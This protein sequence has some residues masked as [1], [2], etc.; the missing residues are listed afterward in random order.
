M[1]TRKISEVFDLCQ[2][3][4][5]KNSGFS[6]VPANIPKKAKAARRAMSQ[7]VHSLMSL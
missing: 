2:N 5:F 7:G 1:V 3:I 6:S 4:P